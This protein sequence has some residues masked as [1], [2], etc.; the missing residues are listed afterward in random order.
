MTTTFTQDEL[1]FMDA[2]LS[3]V[4]EAP[5]DVV[6]DFMRMEGDEFYEKYGNEYYTALADA[7]GVW[8]DALAY[9]RGNK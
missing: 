5:R 7:L 9:A 4:A 6:E 8:Y 1:A 3:N 2:Y